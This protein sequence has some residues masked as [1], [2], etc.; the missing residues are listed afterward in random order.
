[1]K[2]IGRSIIKLI[3]WASRVDD[4]NSNGEISPSYAIN[5]TKYRKS[6]QPVS[7]QQAIDNHDDHRG[8]NFTV[9]SASG[10]KVIQISTYNS[11]TDTHKSKL[12]IVTDKEDLGEELSQIITRE[13]LTH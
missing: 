6:S 2:F 10:G 7:V 13:S 1:M 3:K 4:S 11:S 9:F 8:M 5:S 12:Y